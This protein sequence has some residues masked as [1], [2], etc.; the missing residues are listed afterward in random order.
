MYQ[1]PDHV[2]SRGMHFLNSVNTVGGHDETVVGYFGKAAAVLA[3]KATVIIF[4]S[5][6]AWSA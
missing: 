2:H 6:A 4:L 5:R 3:G 1:V